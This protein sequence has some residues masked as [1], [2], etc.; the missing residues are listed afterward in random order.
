MKSK[1]KK[2]WLVTFGISIFIVNAN[3]SGHISYFTANL[4]DEQ[5]VNNNN[6]KN[7][8]NRENLHGSSGFARIKLNAHTKTITAS[9]YYEGLTSGITDLHIHGPAAAGSNGQHIIHLNPVVGQTSGSIIDF[10]QQITDEQITYLRSGLLYFNIHTENNPNGEIRGQIYVNSPFV[11]V[12]KPYGQS[13]NSQQLHG[14]TPK[15]KAAVNLNFSGSQALVSIEWEN[16]S[17]DVNGGHIHNP[18]GD[19][20]CNFAPP[21]T[22]N[23]NVTDFLCNLNLEESDDLK[24]GQFHIKLHTPTHPNGELKGQIKMR[25][26]TNLDLEGDNKTDISI[27]RPEAGEWWYQKSSDAN[28]PQVIKFG[29]ETDKLVPADYTGDGI[30]DIAVWREDTGEWFVLRSDDYSFFSFP[31]GANGDIPVPA[32]FDADG[33]DDAAI[34][35]PDEGNWYINNSFDETTTIIQ[36]GIAEDIPVAK[37]YDGDG[38][39]DIA[40]YRPSNSQWWINESTDGLAVYKFGDFGDK[41]VPGDF[42]GDGK[43]DV[44][45]WRMLTGEWFILRSED[46]SFFSFPFGSDG[47]IPVASD[48]DGDGKT[49]PAVFRPSNNTWFLQQ[50]TDGFKAVSFGSE[51]DIPI[52][53]AFTP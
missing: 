30:A 15:G 22:A 29:Q 20:I 8:E 5:I 14:N 27:F 37:D 4:D 6:I 28:L 10:Q 23:G 51:N 35:R 53:S 32:D 42:T 52:P 45:V 44:A 13:S 21:Q 48:Y 31:F 9:I 36:F 41:A 43:A 47:D 12:L 26:S 7:N 49:D 11:S 34:F 24:R 1:I 39:T 50:T 3:A 18:N 33:K 17:S 40:I 2:L 19:V 25:N 38:Y 16:L 46:I